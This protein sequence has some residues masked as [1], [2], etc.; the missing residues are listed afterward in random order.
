MQTQATL[1]GARI[2]ERRRL[3]GLKQAD[4][5]KIVGISPS[6]LNLI[7][8]D[9]RRIGGKLLNDLARALG[10]DLLALSTGAEI[11]VIAALQSIAQ[12]HPETA[13]NPAEATA[14]A[15]RFPEWAALMLK[16]QN[17]ITTLQD[18]LTALSDRMSHDPNLAGALHEVI[19]VV[20]AIRSTTSIL[21]EGPELE[22]DWQRRF[23]R[24]L[25][26]D[27]LRLTDG[28]RALVGYLDVPDATTNSTLSPLETVEA[29]F[30]THDYHFPDMEHPAPKSPSQSPSPT[31][32]K[33][34]P[35]AAPFLA[36]YR[37]DAARIPATEL[38]K[39]ARQFDY[40][41]AMIA[42][43]FGTDL[44]QTLRRLASLRQDAGHPAMG[45]VLA[46]AA[47]AITI[48][49]P[50]AGFS[51]PRTAPTCPLWPVFQAFSQPGLPIRAQVRLPGH[52][53]LQLLCYAIAHPRTAP[54]FDAP[55]LLQ[56]IMLMRADPPAH[57]TPRDVAQSCRMC[58]HTACAARRE[59]SALPPVKPHSVG[60]L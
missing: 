26:D 49:R 1:T 37:A 33:A 24:N 47:G 5:A 13:A 18:R 2:R 30:A 60:V 29:Y 3:A 32:E 27:S 7:E 14:L 11:S 57:A 45:L 38:A 52:Q 16:Q 54:Q 59:P 21:V 42:A 9:R 39:V 43:E 35:L 51:P 31:D 23:H 19:S 20:T 28:A 58:P 34:P 44:A 10:M 12:V 25:F 56:A 40:D 48:L 41:P 17:T 6:Y 36:I 22:P 4:L 55:P 53:G 46:D 50:I 15:D 8:H